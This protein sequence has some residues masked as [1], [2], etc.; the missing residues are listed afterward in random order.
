[1]K[2]KECLNGNKMPKIPLIVICS[3]TAT[4]KSHLALQLAQSAGAEILNAD[5]LQVY[6]Y[7]DIGTAKP[8]RKEREKVAHHLID[9]VNPD[10]EYNAAV[11]SEQARAII[12]NLAREGKPVFVV[13]GTGLYIRALLQGIIATPPVDENIRKYYKELRDR[14]G[15]EYV[16]GLLQKRDPQAALHINPNDSVRVIRALEVLDQS[17]QSIIALQQKHLFADCPY[18]VCKIGLRVERDE[19]KKRINLR[20]SQMVETGLLDEVRGLLA[21]GY[22]EKL[23]PL[24]SLGYKQMIDFI[25]KRQSWEQTLDSI[26]RETWQYA[27][28]QMTWFGADKTIN[29]FRP[30]ETEEIESKIEDF[31]PV[32]LT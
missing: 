9:V 8:T 25:G 28:R 27:K 16:F 17:G 20:T 15:R 31:L 32:I 23:K 11:Y 30:E 10:E 24:Q 18:S 12:E 1:M 19:L 13:G 3:P 4:G 29:W 26:N 6:R 21:K 7:M 2:S 14:H 22:S 5:S